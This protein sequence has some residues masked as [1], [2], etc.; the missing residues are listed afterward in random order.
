MSK[1]SFLMIPV[2]GALCLCLSGCAEKIEMLVDSFQNP[3]SIGAE[4]SED[5]DRLLLLEEL[6]EI[7]REGTVT[8][9]AYES[10]TKTEKLWYED[11]DRILK[12]MQTDGE[13]SK[14]GLDSGLSEADVDKIFQCVLSDRPEYFYVEGYTY[15]TF[16]RGDEVIKMELSG[17]YSMEVEEAADRMAQIRE[18][19]DEILQGIS[20][21][22]SDYDKIKYV[23]ETVIRNT[24]Y[25]MNAPDNQ[26]ISSVLLGHASVCQGY[27]KTVQYLLKQ[28]GVECTLVTGTVDGGDRH[29]WNLV[30]AD[31]QYYYVDATWG[32]ASYTQDG[33][34]GT[35]TDKFPEINYDY[36]CIT[37][38]QLM[39]THTI[40]NVVEMPECTSS[41][42]NYYILEGLYFTSL[43]RELLEGCFQKAWENG[44]EDVTLKCADAGVYEEMFDYL[45][46]QQGIF[47]YLGSGE[48]RIS[49]SPNEKQLSLTFWVT[50]E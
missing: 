5:P 17:T 24:D 32:D 20:K 10:L 3:D 36:L 4:S 38:G 29:A 37:S 47:D 7:D 30:K 2:L 8:G 34:A 13:L 16:T 45:I 21:D 1:R 15:T 27:A 26:N 39:R 22:A 33:S 42:L 12:N 25:D 48:D 23:Y 9:Y 11:I 40:E 31:G 49:Y 14:E 35:G 46:T 41:A 19:A 44:R 28:L 43:D 18:A 6:E 50:N